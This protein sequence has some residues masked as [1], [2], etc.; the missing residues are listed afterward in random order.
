MTQEL[1]TAPQSEPSSEDRRSPA[2]LPAPTMMN[3]LD[4]VSTL[5]DHLDANT[6]QIQLLEAKLD[7]ILAQ[8][9]VTQSPKK[10][11]PYRSLRANPLIE[12]PATV[13]LSMA[14]MQWM[15]LFLMGI[16][17]VCLFAASFGAAAPAVTTWLTIVRQILLPVAVLVLGGFVIT[18]LREST[19]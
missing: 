9:I 1:F 6:R 3:P 4:L 18:A 13:K 19:Q 2:M 7:Q 5:H 14:G 12:Y 17:I 16:S 11:R 15:F 10:S 8:L